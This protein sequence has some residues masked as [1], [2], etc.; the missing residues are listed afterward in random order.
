MDAKFQADGAWLRFG[1]APASA[2]ARVWRKCVWTSELK[3]RAMEAR[4][5]EHEL[6]GLVEAHI[7]ET[8]FDQ[9]L[10]YNFND[11]ESHFSLSTM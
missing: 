2:R 5:L 9:C 4:P 11:E 8:I 10:N 3:R 1:D 6:R 7:L